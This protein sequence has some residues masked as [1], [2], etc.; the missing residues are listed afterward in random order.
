[1]RCSLRSLPSNV[2]QSLRHAASAVAAFCAPPRPSL[3]LLAIRP[4]SP[5]RPAHAWGRRIYRS[6]SSLRARARRLAAEQGRMRGG[7]VGRLPARMWGTFGAG[8]V[9]DLH[10]EMARRWRVARWML[11][12]A[13]M[14]ILAVTAGVVTSYTPAVSAMTPF[15]QTGWSG[16]ELYTPSARPV[17]ITVAARLTRPLDVSAMQQSA[18]VT[19]I[20]AGAGGDSTY[21]GAAVGDW[22]PQAGWDVTS[23][24]G[25]DWSVQPW[26][27]VCHTVGSDAQY[28]GWY[29]DSPYTVPVGT[30][31][32]ST[33]RFTRHTIIATLIAQGPQQT[34]LRF[35]RRLPTLHGD[36]QTFPLVEGIV[37]APGPGPATSYMAPQSSD[38]LPLVPSAP[39]TIATT[40]TYA[41]GPAPMPL[42]ATD[43]VLQSH[44]WSDTTHVVSYSVQ[45]R[46]V[47]TRA[48]ITF[49]RAH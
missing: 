45:G 14:G 48:R 28:P 35:V 3:Y 16:T 24:D 6:T 37:E 27:I 2:R 46:T 8:I 40:V 17:T 18:A 7:A 34:D 38:R 29:A 13:L 47:T 20:W 15:V 42:L 39:I 4:P 5:N 31:L 30:V 32:I 10:Q 43:D 26:A 44:A 19:D 49:Y 23:W 41:S 25:R 36:L 11:A 9:A 33:L 1:M 12:M 21:G 22:L